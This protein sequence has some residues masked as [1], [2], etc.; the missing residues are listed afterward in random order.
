MI[1]FL[2]FSSWLEL[3]AER[4]ALNW[5]HPV[6]PLKSSTTA[7]WSCEWNQA[8][9]NALL[10]GVWRH[11]FG[12]WDM[13]R[14]DPDLGLG[15]SIFLE[16]VKKTKGEEP[17]PK[18]IPSGV[19]L[20][21]RCEYLLRAL[22]EY[23]ESQIS[24]EEG[25]G[26]NMQNGLH[27]HEICRPSTST[28][29]LPKRARAPLKTAAVKPSRVIKLKVKSPQVQPAPSASNAQAEESSS[30]ELTEEEDEDSMDEGECKEA[31]RPVRKELRELR[32]N[33]SESLPKEVRGM[34]LILIL[35]TTGEPL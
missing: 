35:F 20:G 22:R 30:S 14:D 32:A 16:E 10:I 7:V 23:Q 19:H 2:C 4:D 8:K 1:C 27:S 13:I 31:M 12:Q 25:D 17:K 3:S 6:S 9:D 33:E 34:Y 5:N 11:G 15:D 21:R 29:N 24:K 18:S 26:E 28:S